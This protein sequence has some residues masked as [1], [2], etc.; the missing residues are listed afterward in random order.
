M[1]TPTKAWPPVNAHKFEG[2]EAHAH[3]SCAIR[4][5]TA[6]TNEDIFSTQGTRCTGNLDFGLN[7]ERAVGRMV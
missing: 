5:Y 7:T 6:P 4:A 3:P 1:T 2:T